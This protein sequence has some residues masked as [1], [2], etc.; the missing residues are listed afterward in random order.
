ML[1]LVAFS[2]F[3]VAQWIQSKLGGLTGDT[4]GAICEI[5]EATGLLVAVALAYLGVLS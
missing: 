5:A 2:S 3:L 4:Y 1:L